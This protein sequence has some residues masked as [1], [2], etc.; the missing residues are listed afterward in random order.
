MKLKIMITM[1]KIFSV[2][3]IAFLIN[4]CIVLKK[5]SIIKIEEPTVPL[6]AT[7]WYLTNIN[8]QPIEINSE[9]PIKLKLSIGNTFKGFGICN[10][11]WGVCKVMNTQIEFSHI[12]QTKMACEKMNIEKNLIDVLKQSKAY[13][14]S[15]NKLNLINSNTT[16]L[17]TFQAVDVIKK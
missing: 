11:I 1:K 2:L 14:I 13:F 9:K 7:T 12:S 5:D 16:I 3:V 17:A 4:G 6:I 10:Q 15:G 8:N